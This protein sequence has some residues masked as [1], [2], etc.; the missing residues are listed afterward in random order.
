MGFVA[1][2]TLEAAMIFTGAIALLAVL[3]LRRDLGAGDAAGLSTVAHALVA[4]KDWTFLLG[5]GL[6]PVLNA[7]CLA[8]V[9][10]RT[11]LVPRII[12][13]IGLVGAPVL[14]A[15]STATLFGAFEQVSAPAMLGALPIA[16]WE[17]SAGVWLTVKGVRTEAP[18]AGLGGSLPVAGGRTPAGVAA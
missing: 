15:S 10:R 11:G 8:T 7:L 9:L 5:P 12:P 1:S 3:T 16:L 4:V 13:T 17:F 2:R 6:M 18:E 14:L